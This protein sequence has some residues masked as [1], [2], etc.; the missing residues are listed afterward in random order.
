MK[1]IIAGF[2][3][4]TS[5]LGILTGCKQTITPISSDTPT[6]TTS[7]KTKWIC[8]LA[9]SESNNRNSEGAF[10]ELNDGRILFAYS[11][12][13]AGGIEDGDCRNRL[14]ITKIYI[15]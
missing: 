15:Y 1:K 7:E 9:P 11:R 3:L 8:D 10:I 12:Y 4:L 14:R 2:I 5:M 13:G 6:S